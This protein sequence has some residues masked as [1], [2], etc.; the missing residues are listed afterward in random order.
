MSLRTA[1]LFLHINSSFGVQRGEATLNSVD[2][3]KKH[4]WVNAIWY[5]QSPNF[6]FCGFFNEIKRRYLKE[7]RE[8][9]YPPP[10]HY[11]SILLHTLLDISVE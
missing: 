1:H 7:R 10:P 11:L 5:G 9:F 4:N 8:Y 2:G 3:R 6:S